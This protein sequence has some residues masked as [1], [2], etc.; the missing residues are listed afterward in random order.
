MPLFITFEGPDGSGKSTQARL[1]AAT[2]RG[3]GW[4]VIETREP[5]GTPI[6]ECLRE[7]FLSPEAP[8]ATPLAMTFLLCAARCQHVL[9]VIEP[10]LRRGEYVICDRFADST[11]AYQSFGEGV[12]LEDVIELTRIAIGGVEPDI[13]ILVD[14]PPDV[15]LKRVDRRGARNRLDAK[16]VA[17][18][19][20]VHDGYLQL[21][22][23]D[24]ARWIRVDGTAP[25]EAVHH[26]IVAAIEPM[27]E[28]KAETI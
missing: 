15:G 20:R 21:M 13:T 5:G 18:H 11:V 10:A 7:L 19:H 17:F 1:L 6:G 23:R 27:L 22:R 24:P 3:R 28:R 8:P 4:P 12:A 14:V 9:D 16:A 2:L 26:A 25:P